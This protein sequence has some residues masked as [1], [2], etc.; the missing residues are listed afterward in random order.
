M[1]YAWEELL[2]K[3]SIT[4]SNP[5]H[6]EQA[7]THSS[8]SNEKSHKV[9]LE[10]L[11]FMG[12]AVCQLFVS[13]L[14]FEAFGDVPEGQLTLLRSNLVSEK[15]MYKIAKSLDLGK[16]VYLGIG[17]EKNNGRE[18]VSLLA[19][20]VESFIGAI[21]L[22]TDINTTRRVVREIFTPYLK[23]LSLEDLMDYKSKLQE[24]VQADSKRSVHYKTV[25]SYGPDNDPTY[26][27]EVYLEDIV[28]GKG[29]GKS[30]KQA[31]KAAAK[32]ALSKAGT[33]DDIKKEG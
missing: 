17:E 21:F 8:F 2:N 26:V 15:G 23:D 9:H 14:V 29:I 31:E 11:E 6:Y 12:D 4:Y 33:I 32:D 30:K 18:R 25:D 10:R 13:E 19:D 24:F 20:L 28:L 27:V 1:K 3:F 5:N 22:D 7:F 16:Y